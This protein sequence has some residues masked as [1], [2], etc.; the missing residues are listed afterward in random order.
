[1]PPP[2]NPSQRGLKLRDRVTNGGVVMGLAGQSPDNPGF[3]F[4]HVMRASAATNTRTSVGKV[5]V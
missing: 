4:P 1:M 5:W 2:P 3:P